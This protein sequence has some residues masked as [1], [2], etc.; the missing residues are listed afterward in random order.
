M[1]RRKKSKTYYLGMMALIFICAIYIIIYPN[2]IA[3]NHGNTGGDSSESSSYETAEN[4][5]QVI[6]GSDD[7]TTNAAQAAIEAIEKKEEALQEKE[8]EGKDGK[9]NN[10]DPMVYTIYQF[11]SEDKLNS[12]F[13]KHGHEMGFSTEQEYLDAANTL[14]NNPLALHKNEAEDGDDIYYLEETNEIAFVSTDHYIR[15]YF[16]CSGKDYFDRQ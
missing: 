2:I 1:K 10:V 6:T 15:T 3:P 5:A 9:A 13:E 12:H 11:R 14:I 8:S 4:A 16:I 7:E